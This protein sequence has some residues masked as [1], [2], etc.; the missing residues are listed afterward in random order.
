MQRLTR[1]TAWCAT[2]QTQVLQAS[3]LLEHLEQWSW[4]PALSE[5]S[6]TRELEIASFRIGTRNHEA[7][8]VCLAV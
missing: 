5:A 2:P 3:P 6:C 4:E 7:L 8:R 1:L